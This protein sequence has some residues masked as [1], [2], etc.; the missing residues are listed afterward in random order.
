MKTYNI[1]ELTPEARAQALVN[2]TFFRDDLEDHT[3][4]ELI[5]FLDGVRGD[6][7]SDVRFTASGM[8]AETNNKGV[9]A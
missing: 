4:T 2:L 9:T 1:H 3:V 7:Q 6:P 5:D 8:I